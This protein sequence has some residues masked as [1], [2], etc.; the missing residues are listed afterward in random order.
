LYLSVLT[1][2]ACQV[3]GYLQ[4][5]WQLILVLEGHQPAARGPPA[6]RGRPAGLAD[7]PSGRYTAPF[8]P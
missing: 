5:A 7:D 6:L 1:Q 3:H 4:N 2:A 8:A